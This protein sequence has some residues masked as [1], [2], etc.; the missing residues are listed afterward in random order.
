MH[1]VDNPELA[2]YLQYLALSDEHLEDNAESVEDFEELLDGVG[3]PPAQA[4]RH[5]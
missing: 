5:G 4:A 2:Q 3:T 1:A